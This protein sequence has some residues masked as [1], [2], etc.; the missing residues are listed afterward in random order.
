MRTAQAYYRRVD[1]IARHFGK[2]PKYLAQKDVRS[3]LI[4]L[5]RDKQWAASTTRQ[6]VAC[7]SMYYGDMLG[8][9]WYR[10]MQ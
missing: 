6:S 2:D 10:G 1:L 8:R 7:L 9:D 3:Y 4:H 5:K